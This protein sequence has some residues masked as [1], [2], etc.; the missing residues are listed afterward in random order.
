MLAVTRERVGSRWSRRLLH[1]VRPMGMIVLSC[2][3]L[4]RVPL[5]KGKVQVKAAVM[6][7]QSWLYLPERPLA[8]LVQRLVILVVIAVAMDP[9]TA[10]R[11]TPEEAEA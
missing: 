1:P 6:R 8:W 5:M 7:L 4:W 11:L 3:S 10:M 9:M 2:L